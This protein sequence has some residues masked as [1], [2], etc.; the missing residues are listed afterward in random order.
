M[1]RTLRHAVAPS[2]RRI[3][4]PTQAPGLLSDNRWEL[5]SLE[6]LE[7]RTLFAAGDLDATFGPGGVDGNGIVTTNI[8][9]GSP[10]FDTG[11]TILVQ[12]DNKIL[13]GGTSDA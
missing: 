13:V 6:R 5:P 3:R 8:V 10:S 2:P 11:H 7:T 1:R 12:P 4:K 9:T